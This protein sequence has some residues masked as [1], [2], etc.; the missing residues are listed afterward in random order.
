MKSQYGHRFVISM[1]FGLYVVTPVVPIEKTRLYLQNNKAFFSASNHTVIKAT[2]KRLV[3]ELNF[4]IIRTS[5]A[6]ASAL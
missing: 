1:V 4:E 2:N 6:M 5:H 3:R